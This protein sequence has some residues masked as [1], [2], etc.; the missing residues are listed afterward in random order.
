MSFPAYV[1]HLISSNSAVDTTPDPLLPANIRAGNLLVLFI[2]SAVAGAI[3]WPAGWN[4][5]Y[6]ES[7]DG[8]DDQNAAA[9]RKADGTEGASIALTSGNGKWVA[10]CYQIANCADPNV[11]PPQLS[12]VAT[13]TTAEPD[14]TTVTPTGGANDYLWLTM[15][16]MEGEQTGITAYPTNY[17]VG[18]TGLISSGTGGATTTNVR[19]AAAIRTNLNAASH[20]APVWDVTGTM[21]N[22]V[23]YTLAVHPS[24]PELIAP[25]EQVEDSKQTAHPIVRSRNVRA[26]VAALALATATANSLATFEPPPVAPDTTLSWVAQDNLAPPR[27]VWQRDPPRQ[28]SDSDQAALL[29]DFDHGPSQVGSDLAPRR[30]PFARYAKASFISTPAEASVAVVSTDVVAGA[31]NLGP[32]PP[33]A[34][35]R[36]PWPKSHYD[37]D[38]LGAFA[39]P[40]NTDVPQLGTNL[41]PRPSA[42]RRLPPKNWVSHLELPPQTL[43]DSIEWIPSMNRRVSPPYR[44]FPRRSGYDGDLLTVDAPGGG[45]T[46]VIIFTS[47]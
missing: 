33:I 8:S 1:N 7:A 32:P 41:S 14:A 46:Y 15:F 42:L 16:G 34:L 23:A 22:W 12:T 29:F 17:T 2:R 4:E 47:Q 31:S 43:L 10:V 19:M 39:A 5:L 24:P 28:Q 37:G 3:G 11:T 6:D 9:W 13:G 45:G 21:T 20:D 30:A 38:L 27:T 35:R 18:Q 25:T 36:M 26:A 40:V 44:V